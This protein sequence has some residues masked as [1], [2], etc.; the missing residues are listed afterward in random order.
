[1][2]LGLSDRIDLTASI[3]VSGNF[4][5]G[6]NVG[7]RFW[8]PRENIVNLERQHQVANGLCADQGH[9]ELTNGNTIDYA[10]V[11]QKILEIASQRN[12]IKLM[13][14]PYNAKKLAEDLLNLHGPPR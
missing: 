4:Q 13:T 3:I 12:L 10:F 2:G 11:Q 14:D 6:F 9:I 8:L 5:Y 7:C 1:V